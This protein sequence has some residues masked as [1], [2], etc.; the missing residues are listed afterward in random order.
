MEL[1]NK[2]LMTKKVDTDADAGLPLQDDEMEQERPKYV[3]RRQIVWFNTIGFLIIHLGAMY[4]LYLLL[5][6]TMVATI[7]WSK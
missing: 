7:V 3:Y 6:S 2:E 4:G 1:L 5:T